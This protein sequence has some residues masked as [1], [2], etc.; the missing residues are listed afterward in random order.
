MGL[1]SL[2][3]TILVLGI[4]FYLVYWVIGQIPLPPPF[5]A[6]AL[7]ILALIVVILLLSV[8]FGGLSLPRLNL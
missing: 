6:V 8:L 2:L 3:I 7:A 5:R 4:I 1:I